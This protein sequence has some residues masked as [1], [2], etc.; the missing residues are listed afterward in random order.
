MKLWIVGKALP[1]HD[2]QRWEFCGVFSTKELAEKACLS[3]SYFVGPA[4]LDE[5]LPEA[6]AFWPD[7]YYPSDECVSDTI[8]E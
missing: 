5:Q 1:D 7:A 3:E 8:A 4:T 2:E 6:P